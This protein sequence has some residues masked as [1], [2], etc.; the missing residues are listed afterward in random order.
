MFLVLNNTKLQHHPPFLVET[1]LK[2][3]RDPADP[4]AGV[5]AVHALH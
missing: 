2:Y 4:A 5:S 1:C 3:E